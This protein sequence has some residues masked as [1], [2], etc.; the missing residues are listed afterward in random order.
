M[1]IATRR[2]T[3]AL[4][5]IGLGLLLPAC[6]SQEPPATEPAPAPVPEEPAPAP[7]PR[8]TE[9][10]EAGEWE[11]ADPSPSVLSPE[12]LNRMGVLQ[13]IYFDYDKSEI[14]AD[15]RPTLQANAQWLR[16][17]QGAKILIE[18]NCDERGTREYNMA[19]GNRRATASME[20]LVSLGVEAN[21]VEIISYGEERPVAQGENEAAWTRNRR[22]DFKVVASSDA[23]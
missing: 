3:I 18:G 15:Q 8:E 9:A 10:P 23:P 1:S 16:E 21:R 2:L 7:A 4:L 22:A 6:S 11:A 13:T 20:Y 19:L 17:N 12:E 5:L 14:R